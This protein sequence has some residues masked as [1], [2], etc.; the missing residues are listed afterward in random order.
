VPRN[1]K[2]FMVEDAQLIFRNFEGREQTFNPAGQRNF[3]CILDLDTAQ[4]MEADGWNIRWTTP[5]EEGDVPK[6]YIKI[7]VGYKIFPPRAVLIA[8]GVSTHLDED[9]VG[10][11]DWVD[12]A[13]VDLFAHASEWN[14]G[15]K[16][17]TSAY[18]KS[19]F[20]TIAEDP[21]EIKYGVNRVQE[22][23]QSET[24]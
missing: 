14:H 10:M 22:L 19:I 2:T 8:G 6:P 11:L 5:K 24:T 13:K 7:K 23:Q 21:L 15:N 1:D 20:V 16:S 17:G 18:L 12:I 3:C 9:H 4:A